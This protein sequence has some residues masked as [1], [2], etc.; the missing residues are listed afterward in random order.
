VG[1][2][3][4]GTRF[5]DFPVQAANTI[6]EALIVPVYD[7]GRVPLG[8][9]WIASHDGRQFDATDARILQGMA[10]QL[11]LAI[12]DRKEGARLRQAELRAQE[13]GHRV[14]NNLQMVSNLLLMQAASMSTPEATDSLK[15]AAARL[16][17]IRSV[18][19]QF[20]LATGGAGAGCLAYLKSLC[21]GI[22]QSLVGDTA[23]PQ[24]EVDGEEADLPADRLVPLGLI[25]NEL[26]TNAAKHGNG[27][28]IMVRFQVA[29]NGY[30]ITV[31][32][33]GNGLPEGFDP[34]RTQG[35]GM[36]IVASLVKE[37][38][39]GLQVG[40]GRNGRGSNFRLTFS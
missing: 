11:L 28:R 16:A 4:W 39:S 5:F 30:A 6:T 38:G 18:H 9:C 17:A 8:T 14:S 12:K 21:E 13:I 35:L 1:G 32:D 24:L 40:R 19:H 3:G 26:V 37:I 15:V 23:I 34:R 20:D 33:D 25:V 31:A 2:L 10:I 7:T 22:A 36:S 29:P 27:S